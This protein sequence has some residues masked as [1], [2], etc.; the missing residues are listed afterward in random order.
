MTLRKGPDGSTM[1]SRPQSFDGLGVAAR[2]P[3]RNPTL[4]SYSDGSG[5]DHDPGSLLSVSRNVSEI[6][7]QYHGRDGT[8]SVSDKRDLG[9]N[10]GDVEGGLSA[11][12]AFIDGGKDSSAGNGVEHVA[13]AAE[14]QREARQVVS[15]DESV[16]VFLRYGRL[17]LAWEHNG[18]PKRQ[19][20]QLPG[21]LL[22]RE[23][24]HV[25]KHRH[26]DAL[27]REIEEVAE[28]ALY[29]A[30]V[31][32]LRNAIYRGDLDAQAVPTQAANLMGSRAL[33]PRWLRD[34]AFGMRCYD[35]GG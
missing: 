35:A 27:R 1:L 5:A 11:Q 6:L 32:D 13:V 17:S 22:G 30:A 29:G 31:M 20:Q 21:E 14:R 4:R 3:G 10:L 15:S 2:T 9:V 24:L 34:S 18:F 8:L 16:E 23:V 33:C 7:V 25:A 19:A 26:G 28:V 12:Q